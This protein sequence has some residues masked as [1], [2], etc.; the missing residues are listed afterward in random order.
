MLNQIE[1]LL[2]KKIEKIVVPG[3][4][5]DP[6]APQRDPQPR[7][8]KQ[9]NGHAPRRNGSQPNWRRRADRHSDRSRSRPSV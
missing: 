9:N 3:F 6:N 5:P 1:Q 8:P 2:Q 4:E 7:R